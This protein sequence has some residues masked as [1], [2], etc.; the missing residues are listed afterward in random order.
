MQENQEGLAVWVW[1]QL[2][3]SVLR[4]CGAGSA[5]GLRRVAQCRHK[6]GRLLGAG[7]GLDHFL[8]EI[9]LGHGS[10]C[11]FTVT[12]LTKPTGNFFFLN[13]Y[14]VLSFVDTDFFFK[15]VTEF[16]KNQTRVL[17]SATT[18]LFIF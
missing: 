8:S 16:K 11:F 9:F 7:V 15:H 6:R 14:I 12:R 17:A 4:G 13:S 2:S 5:G 1:K 10:L 18:V 3:T